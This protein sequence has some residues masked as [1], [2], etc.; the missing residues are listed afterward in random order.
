LSNADNLRV[1]YRPYRHEMQ[2]DGTTRWLERSN[3]RSIRINATQPLDELIRKADIVIS[4]TSSGT[5]W[6]EVIVLKK[7]LILY[8]DPR[9][10][11]VPLSPHL[12][13]DLESACYWCKSVEELVAA[14]HRLADEG[15]AFAA[16]LQQIDTT[17]FIRN[18]VLHR[19]DGQ[20]VPRVIS[21]LNNVCRHGQ[22][23]DEWENST[24]VDT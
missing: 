19:D 24:L 11:P 18:Y 20:C 5:T 8:F 3:L 22:S 21:F 23:V 12:V 6:N 2:V 17:A 9:Q 7:P 16:E 1:I 15:L 4:D 10:W 13:S 14:V